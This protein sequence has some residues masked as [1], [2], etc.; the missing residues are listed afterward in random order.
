[1]KQELKN[2]E[3]SGLDPHHTFHVLQAQIL[4]LQCKIEMHKVKKESFVNLGPITLFSDTDDND[5]AN[6]AQNDHLSSSLATPKQEP[7]S[8]SDEDEKENINKPKTKRKRNLIES[9]TDSDEEDNIPLAVLCKKLLP[10]PVKSI[11]QPKKKRKKQ[12]F[13]TKPPPTQSSKPV[14][15]RGNGPSTANDDDNTSLLDGENDGETSVTNKS[16]SGYNSTASKQD[17][18]AGSIENTLDTE[19]STSTSKTPSGDTTGT[20]KKRKQNFYCI[21]CDVVEPSL[22]ELNE[23]FRNKHDWVHCHNCGKP[24]PMRSALAK[25]MYT[26]GAKLLQ[27]NQCDK[28]FPFESQLASHKISNEEE[29]QFPCDQCPK[30]LKNK[31]DLKKHLSAHTDETYKCQYCDDYVASDICN[32]KGHLKTHDKLLRY[33]CRYCAKCF[34][35]Y[36][37]RR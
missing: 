25:H 34:K 24:F 20:V 11:K 30:R 36:N 10:L 12:K 8:G 29:G 7:L 5:T 14:V 37:Q 35:H 6:I 4:N 16:D 15:N 13:T 17:K 28:Q 31:S 23:H 21:K 18:T 27:C 22:R 33:I 26:C 1:M 2:G 19:P 9:S 3:S 32:L